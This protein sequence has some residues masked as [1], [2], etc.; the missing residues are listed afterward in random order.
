MRTDVGDAATDVRIVR[1]DQHVRRAVGRHRQMNPF[2]G[3]AC[4]G[5]RPGRTQGGNCVSQ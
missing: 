2:Q 1:A 5:N 3:N 4:T